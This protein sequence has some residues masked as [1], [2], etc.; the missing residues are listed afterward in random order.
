MS[1]SGSY[2][3][4]EPSGVFEAPRVDP[5]ANAQAQGETPC[6][7]TWREQ[8]IIVQRVR[9]YAEIGEPE[10]RQGFDLVVQLSRG[11]R[12]PLLVDLRE[13]ASISSAARTFFA[14]TTVSDTATR[15]AL[16]QGS[17]VTALAGNLF[18]RI[19]KPATE[20]K[21]FTDEQ[22]ARRW[23]LEPR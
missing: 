6:F 1:D 17:T 12:Y 13:P 3:R 11:K 14:S 2:S 7:V 9:R 23:L 15:V 16:L 8:D 18:V 10:A 22:K 20:T 21:I 5:P 19:N 4:N